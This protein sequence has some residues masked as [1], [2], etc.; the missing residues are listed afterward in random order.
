M[1]TWAELPTR[2]VWH[3]LGEIMT[4][5]SG[6]QPAKYAAI[7]REHDYMGRNANPNSMARFGRN[8]GAANTRDGEAERALRNVGR[9]ARGTTRGRLTA[10]GA[11]LPYLL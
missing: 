7:S 11:A 9:E 5:P 8:L 4:N 10:R 6:C 2:I 3:E 1:T